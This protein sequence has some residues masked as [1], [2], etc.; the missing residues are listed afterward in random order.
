MKILSKLLITLAILSYGVVPLLADLNASHLFHPD[1][2]PHARLHTAWL[3]A[4]CSAI[5]LVAL[6]VT[7]IKDEVSLGGVLSICVLGG[8]W[9]ATLSSHLYGGSL[10][11][12]GGVDIHVLGFDANS[13]VFALTSTAALLGML[14]NRL[15]I[16]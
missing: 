6:Y 4:T 8:F 2:T 5:G 12:T 9:V 16:K 11:D 3:L 14:L 1:W 15:S 10:A 7:W 13:F